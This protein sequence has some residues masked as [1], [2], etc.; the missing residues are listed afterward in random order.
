MLETLMINPLSP[1]TSGWLIIC[2]AACLLTLNVPITLIF[3]I[4]IKFYEDP[5]FFSAEI[6]KAGI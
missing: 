3:K 4:F 5:T 1:L 6:V 2:L